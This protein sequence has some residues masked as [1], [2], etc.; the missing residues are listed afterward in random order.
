ML[1]DHVLLGRI[2]RI[3]TGAN[4]HNID[5]VVCLYRGFCELDRPKDAAIYEAKL[6]QLLAEAALAQ[7]ASTRP[8]LGTANTT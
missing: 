8:M 7:R 3:K 2:Q 4:S 5:Q 1:I 6:Y